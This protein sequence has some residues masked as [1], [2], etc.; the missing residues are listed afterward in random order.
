MDIEALAEQLHG[1]ARVGRAD[2]SLRKRFNVKDAPGK[3]AIAMVPHG[4][5]KTKAKAYVG[6]LPGTSLKLLTRGQPLP[7]GTVRM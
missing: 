5:G 1:L 2:D 4:E 6:G 3:P 7:A